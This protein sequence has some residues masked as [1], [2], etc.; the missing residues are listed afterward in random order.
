MQINFNSLSVSFKGF[1]ERL[2]K[3][4]LLQLGLKSNNID[5]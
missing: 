3:I 1:S 2:M 5:G 4:N